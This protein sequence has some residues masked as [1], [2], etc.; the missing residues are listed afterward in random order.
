MVASKNGSPDK[1]TREDVCRIPETIS[2]PG[3]EEHVL[4]E[5][6][7]NKIFEKCMQLSKGKPK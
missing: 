4:N 1:I 5:W 7:D 2:F 3:E 6:K